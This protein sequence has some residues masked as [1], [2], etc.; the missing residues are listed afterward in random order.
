MRLTLAEIAQAVGGALHPATASGAARAVGIDTRRLPPQA[1]FVALA[2]G[3]SDGHDH[4]AAAQEAGAAA[5]LVARVQESPLPQIAVEDTL[6]ALWQLARFWRGRYQGRIA[7]VTGSNGK[8]SVKE[9][10]YGIMVAAAGEARVLRSAGNYNNHLGVPL[11]LLQLQPAHEW[12]ALEAG[13][14]HAG[15]LTALSGLMRP[16][17]AVIN[18]AQRAHIGNFA[19][20]RD[21]AAA[22]GELLSGLPPDGVAVLNADDAHFPMWRELAAGRRIVS[23]GKSAEATLQGGPTADGIVFNNEAVALA[24]PGEHNKMNALAA[25]A[26]A[27]ALG[28]PAAAIARGLSNYRGVGGRLTTHFLAENIVLIDDTYNA[29][30]DS[31]AAAL[32]VLV[33]TARRRQAQPLLAMGDMLALG[34]LSGSAHAAL[35]ADCA[36]QEVRLFGIGEHMQSAQAHSGYGEHFDSH[37]ALARAVAELMRPAARLCVLVKG[38]RGMRMEEVVAGLMSARPAAA[39]EG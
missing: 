28:L 14:D 15:E 2:G 19:S 35:V 17:V 30:P 25:A 12:A 20:L 23:F 13:M 9:M 33:Q 8:T 38:S 29:N 18:N 21:I 22:K 10:L 1:L 32:E 31:A 4:L 3:G 26:A 39:A 34:A 5:A 37:G 24:V 11:T 16:R 36:A 6:A 7:A 27:D